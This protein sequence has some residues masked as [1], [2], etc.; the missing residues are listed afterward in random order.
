MVGLAMADEYLTTTPGTQ[1]GIQGKIGAPGKPLCDVYWGSHG[2][3]K[4]RHHRGSRHKCDPCKWGPLH[5]LAQLLG[6]HRRC[7]ERWPYY[8]PETRFY[9]EDTGHYNL[10]THSEG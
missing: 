10:R 5:A 2:C 9:G 6:M 4:R 1:L 7:A 8:G 3:D